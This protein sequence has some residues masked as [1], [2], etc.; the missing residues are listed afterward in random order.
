M[1]EQDQ[2]PGSSGND[3]DCKGHENPP[4][5]TKKNQKGCAVTGIDWISQL[6]DSLIVQILSLMPVKDAFR[7]TILSKRWQYLWT[8]IDNLI[9][10]SRNINCSDSL[11]V[12]K[13]IS[14]M[15]NNKVEDIDLDI[16][17]YD[18]E[19]YI[20]PQVLCSSSSVLKLSC[21]CCRISEDCTLN[22]TSL[23]SLTLTH[24][25]LRDE[26]IEQIISSCP[27]LEALELQEFCGFHRLHIT[28]PKCRRLQLINHGHPKGDWDSSGGDCFLEVVA[29]Y[30]RH[31]K[32]FGG[33]HLYGN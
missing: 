22:W 9:F 1:G 2:C 20:L 5:K 30:V 26:H 23:K 21:T 17:Y 28:S 24:L 25:F 15:D 29:P 13:F 7:T 14:F 8:S 11:A 27:Q 6:P 4:Q 33:F 10:G 31:L 16:W 18:Q 19:S 32:I 3:G 12:N